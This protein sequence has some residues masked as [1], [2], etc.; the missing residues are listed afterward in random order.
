M[1]GLGQT[2]A[3]QKEVR[4]HETQ[5]FA[6]STSEPE[7]TSKVSQV[8]APHRKRRHKKMGNP[9]ISKAEFL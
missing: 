3:R 8:P 1:A 9:A 2:N 4:A 6:A 5:A 7:M